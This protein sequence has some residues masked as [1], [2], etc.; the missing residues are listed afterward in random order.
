MKNLVLFGF[1]GSGKTTV[2]RLAAVELGLKFVDMDHWIEQE[3]GCSITEIFSAIGEAGFRDLESRA[4]QT[5]ASQAGLVIATGGGVVLRSANIGTFGR[6]GVLICLRIDAATALART[7]GHSHR[8]LLKG[9]H[10]AERISALLDQ[11][12]PFYDAIPN[13]VESAG[14]PPREVAREVI[15][16]Y[17]NATQ[18]QDPPSSPPLSEKPLS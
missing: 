10:P 1:M 5:L 8:P 3:E 7:R 13:G 6:T 2:G 17:R 18:I 11:R 16:I 15:R 12:K 14:R 9:D 4:A